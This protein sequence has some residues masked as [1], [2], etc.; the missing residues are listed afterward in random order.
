V[1]PATSGHAPVVLAAAE[2][3]NASTTRFDAEHLFNRHRLNQDRRT[4]HVA[5]ITQVDAPH[6][7]WY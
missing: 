2:V 5:T 7:G 1:H 4:T 3:S 6:G